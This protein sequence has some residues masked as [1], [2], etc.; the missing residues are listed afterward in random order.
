MIP[1]L[2]VYSGGGIIHQVKPNVSDVLGSDVLNG[3]R[4]AEVLASTIASTVEGGC[5]RPGNVISCLMHCWYPIGDEMRTQ[6]LSIV[7][8]EFQPENWSYLI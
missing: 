7:E 8:K 5:I 3:Y 6:R 1:K 2:R 4:V